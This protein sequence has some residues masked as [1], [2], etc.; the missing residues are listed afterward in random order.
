MT[1]HGRNATN[2]AVY[3]YHERAKDA[4]AAGYGTERCRLNKDSLNNWDC[5]SLT[6]QPC[7]NPL[8]SPQGFL[9]DKEALLKYIIE[10]KQEYARKMKEYE[11]QKD[12]D[13]KDLHEIADAEKQSNREKFEKSEQ[14]I[15][16]SGGPT[17]SSSAKAT[18]P[19]FW[20][21]SMT[22]Q[23]SKTKIEKP[24]K[25]VYCPM[26][27]K[28]LKFKDMIEVKF[29]LLDDEGEE[30][31]A[32]STVYVAG[33]PQGEPKKKSLVAKEERYK[34]AVTQDILNNGTPVAVLRPTG[35]VVTVECVEKIIKKDMLHPLT[36]AKLVE[37]DII[38]L[39]RGGTGYAATNAKLKATHYR[40]NLAIS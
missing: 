20:V 11:R 26:S 7:R 14:S 28:P 8:V 13:I 37:K 10:K 35:D 34:C 36:G 9:F 6:L 17:S 18:L 22:P 24:D 30:E 40:P 3:T 25:T 32:S 12:R 38:Y 19:S 16:P 23:A 5:C 4:K 39:Q 15:L 21:P 27:G 29:K 31:K 33:K 2:S 1:R